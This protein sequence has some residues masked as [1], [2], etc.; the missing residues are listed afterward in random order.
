MIQEPLP[1]VVGLGTGQP[2][3]NRSDYLHV[4]KKAK[5]SFCPF[6]PY[7]S[8]LPNL[9]H[10]LEALGK[11]PTRT[12]INQ[13]PSA[14]VE[15]RSVLILPGPSLGPA[16]CPEVSYGMGPRPG[17]LSMG[18]CRGLFSLL[19]EDWGSL[20]PIWQPG[21]EGAGLKHLSI[22][23]TL[24]IYYLLEFSTLRSASIRIIAEYLQAQRGR[25]SFPRSHSTVSSTSG[26]WC[27]S[28]ASSPGPPQVR[29]TARRLPASALLRPPTEL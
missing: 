23:W 19:W 22:Y 8:I 13:L 16:Q 15:T 2:A 6:P 27:R 20:R 29:G 21:S 9:S 12:L 7:T 10:P 4:L 14:S 3:I 28:A 1:D 24:Y 18:H 11:W 5:N 17:V 26:G 25:V